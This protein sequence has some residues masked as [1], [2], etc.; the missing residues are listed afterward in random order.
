MPPALFDHE[1]SIAMSSIF[2]SPASPKPRWRLAAAAVL[3]L[4]GAFGTVHAQE[5][6][7][8][9]STTFNTRLMVP[10]KERIE[11]ASGETLKVLPNK[12]SAGVLALLEG[13]AELAMISG[14]LG[15]EMS[16]VEKLKPG[17]DMKN[18]KSHE[19]SRTRVSF[20]VNPAN[21][22][23]SATLEQIRRALLGEITNWSELG[24]ENLPIRVVVVRVG[25]DLGSARLPGHQGGRAGARSARHG[26]A[27]PCP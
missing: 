23:R 16:E 9:G 24:G 10:H 5:V 3:W 25:R 4:A 6:V 1:A 26:A 14:P 21:R 8:Q 2:G 12:S 7:V 27:Q 18:L 17:V 20:A 13:R 11:A 22:V 15:A 19:V